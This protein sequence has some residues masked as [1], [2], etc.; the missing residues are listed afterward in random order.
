MKYNV[1][2]DAG[3]ARQGNKS[4]DYMLAEVEGVELY[5]EA[6]PVA[7]DECGTYDALRA[8]IIRQ[9][10]GKGIDPATLRFAYDD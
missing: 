8:E 6:V 1:R 4:I 2:Y 5:A 9:A 7:D 10:E 3:E